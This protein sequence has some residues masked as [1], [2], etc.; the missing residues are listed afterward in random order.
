MA[1]VMFMKKTSVGTLVHSVESSQKMIP[2]ICIFGI[3]L[4]ASPLSSEVFLVLGQGMFVLKVPLSSAKQATP[5][6]VHSAQTAT[7]VAAECS[8]GKVYWTDTAG[9]AVHSAS[10]RAGG[11][12]DKSFVTAEGGFPEVKL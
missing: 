9:R 1:Y 10:F 3:V 5:L 12:M 11:R 8:T 4:S 7:G 2:C 6:A